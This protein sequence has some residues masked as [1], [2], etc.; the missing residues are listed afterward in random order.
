MHDTDEE[1]SSQFTME[2][3]SFGWHYNTKPGNPY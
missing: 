2:L 3:Y 1:L